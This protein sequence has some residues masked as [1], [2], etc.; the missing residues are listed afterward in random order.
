LR[1]KY[2]LQQNHAIQQQ[3][4]IMNNG[5]NQNNIIQSSSTNAQQW[6]S[7]NDFHR[8]TSLSQMNA[9]IQNQLLPQF[10]YSTQRPVHVPSHVNFNLTQHLHDDDDEQ[11]QRHATYDDI[12]RQPVCVCVCVY[13]YVFIITV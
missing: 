7:Q 4:Q 6:P 13:A 10:G 9:I 5:I 3:H 1:Q 12:V 8:S 11:Q 2:L